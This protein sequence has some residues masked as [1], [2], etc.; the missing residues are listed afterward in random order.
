MRRKRNWR[1]QPVWPVNERD[2]RHE[3][4]RSRNVNPFLG[5]RIR[6]MPLFAMNLTRGSRGLSEIQVIS[7]STS[8]FIRDHPRGPIPLLYL[9][10][11]TTQRRRAQV[12]TRRRCLIAV[13]R[14]NPGILTAQHTAIR[15]EIGPIRPN[16]GVLHP[17]VNF[18][19]REG[20]GDERDRFCD[21]RE[22]P[23]EHRRRQTANTRREPLPEGYAWYPW[24]LKQRPAG[25]FRRR[26]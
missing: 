26:R 25:R 15:H 11:E 13:E 7:S 5:H 12:R 23:F 18:P 20:N 14:K 16:I 2:F 6:K 3:R 21:P 22:E 9:P 19:C 1:I 8:G 10:P 24:R 17:V 4:F